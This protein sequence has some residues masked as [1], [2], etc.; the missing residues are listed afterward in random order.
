MEQ[1]T[2]YT[3][4]VW[5]SV[6]Y[7]VFGWL[8]KLMF[9][10]RDGYR[11]QES[12]LPVTVNNAN[13]TAQ[14]NYSSSSIV[15]SYNTNI[16]SNW[17]LI[18]NRHPI[19]N[20]ENQEQDAEPNYFEDLNMA[21]S[22]NKQN[23][24]CRKIMPKKYLLNLV[25]SNPLIDLPS[26]S[27]QLFSRVYTPNNSQPPAPST[28][29]YSNYQSDRLNFDAQNAYAGNELGMLDECPNDGWEDDLDLSADISESMK[30]MR[31]EERE[32]RIAEHKRIRMEKELRKSK[33]Q[34]VNF[35]ATKIS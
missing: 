6:T 5:T 27:L 30:I 24:V 29:N 33:S 28:S 13:K 25:N 19:N 16:N 8:R 22:L 7:L 15:N 2:H 4:I 23:K 14:F 10:R 21:P 1:V 35:M 11:D 32:R 26:L 34:K 9:W 18:N 31:Q 20:T 3:Q 17:N 12:L